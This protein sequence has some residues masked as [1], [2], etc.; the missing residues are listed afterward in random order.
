MQG[1]IHETRARFG[2][3]GRFL[4]GFA[5]IA[6]A[7]CSGD[8]G[9]LTNSTVSSCMQCHNGSLTNDYGGPGIENP[10]PFVGA[11]T[12][13][14]TVC[15]GGNGNGTDQVTSHVPPPP[16]VGDELN[17]TNDAKAYFNRLT[18]A[19]LDRYPNYTVGGRTYTA[20]DYLQFVNPGDL[21]VVTRGRSCGTCHANH[22]EA[23][24]NSLLATEVGIFS[25]ASYASG[26]ENQVPENQGL[27]HDTAGDFGFR[28]ATDPHFNAA[29]AV[30]GAVSRLIEVPIY[31]VFGATGPDDI[32]N[33]PAYSAA[34]IADDRNADN[35]VVT[36]SPLAHLLAEQVIFTCGDCHLGSAGQNNR[37]GDFRSSGCS[38]CHMPYSLGGRSGST[39]PNVNKVEPLDPDA[40][41]APERSHLRSHKIAN[42]AKTL[43]SGVRVPGIDDATCAGCHQGS[44]R[45]VMQYWG[46][47]LDQNADVHN[48]R[49]YPANPAS[50][51]TTHND[52]RLF[53]PA[54]G[55]NTF[56]GRNGNQYL[57][58]E[59]YDN[60]G[61]D[62]TPA[63]VHY[64]AGLGCID[65]HGSNDMH[66]GNVDDPN[67]PIL[68]RMEQNVS[69]RCENCHGTIESYA[70]TQA[71]T[72]YDGAAAQV[73]VDGKGNPL[74]HVYKNGS[75]QYFLKSRLT[76]AVHYIP[77][78][79]DTVGN[80]GTVN[81]L[82]S[83]PVYDPLAS[84]AMGR[85]DADPTNGVGPMQTGGVTAGFSHTDRMDCVACHGSWTNTCMG[86]HLSGEYNTGN[87]FSNITG[88]RIVYKQLTADF[89]YQSPLF[90]QLGVNTR[91]RITQFSS[92]TKVFYRWQDQNDVLSRRFA[93][94]DRNGEGND[95]ASGYS[96]LSHNSIMAHSI[97]G[98]VAPTKEGPRYCVA[99]HLTNTGLANYATQYD[100]F[101]T[102]LE[103]HD[104]GSL[105]FNLLRTQF[106][107]NTGNQLNSP[108]FA[109]MAAGLGTGMFLFDEEGCPA[110]PLDTDPNRKGC[111][112][113]DPA[114]HFS[115][116]HVYFDLD[117]IVEPNG[118]SNGSSNHVWLDPNVGPSMRD[119]AADLDFAGPLGA[120]LIRKLCDPA[121]G[122]VLDSWLDANS[123]PQGDAPNFI[124]P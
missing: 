104:F 5:L 122:I 63:D 74:R 15:H 17:Q 35:S 80:N 79:K 28:A 120:T 109:H 76:G 6:L 92:N 2:D 65:C 23:V 116:S 84:Y 98:R 71:G 77:Q 25:G 3:V 45:T 62:D 87:N 67:R 91:G 81:P 52:T 16:E 42:I 43:P 26:L 46:I 36:G 51:Q 31:S 60:D 33:N 30:V 4:G 123:T 100:A 102:A 103:N 72:T 48:N 66:G 29:T 93:F 106:G 12:I 54:V 37:A 49:Q 99:C 114:G 75:G 108:F 22:A 107:Q 34:A 118:V 86:C 105:N 88:D 8:T 112:G 97:R 69:I 64:E 50:F 95:S 58:F 78:T 38:A 39:D 55:N 1:R 90:F 83:Q 44:N 61:R 96:S 10:H 56:N 18:L 20:L 119:G 121:T 73:A 94:T 53:P 82:T 89:T 7:A 111:D 59:D 32:F 9:S 70:A 41:H 13:Q 68:S 101:R 14:C 124:V 47:R 40:I 110:N 19:G 113:L 117:R 21:R 115:A 85:V 57:L 24:G 27:H 11:D